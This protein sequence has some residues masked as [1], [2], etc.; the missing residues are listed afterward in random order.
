[1]PVGTWKLFRDAKKNICRGGGAN[2]INL[3]AT[4]FKLFFAKSTSNVISERLTIS[5]WGSVTSKVASTSGLH[6][7]ASGEAL[8]AETW[9]QDGGSGMKWDCSA[10]VI[11]ALGS[12]ISSVMY[13]IIATSGGNLLAVCSLSNAA[14]TIG[15]GNTL[16]ITMHANGVFAL[17]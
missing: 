1:M 9:S 13:A 16:T 17:S 8:L 3:S 7:S 2:A 6:N 15:A 11:T 10:A 4:T 12:P 5:T 14:F